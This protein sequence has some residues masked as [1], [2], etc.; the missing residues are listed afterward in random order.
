MADTKTLGTLNLLDSTKW[1]AVERDHPF[2]N[3]DREISP[4]CGGSMSRLKH[5]R[6]RSVPL[7][8]D[9]FIY[10]ATAAVR[11]TNRNTLIAELIAAR[12]RTSGAKYYVR[13]VDNQVAAD[14]WTI[15]TF[16]IRW[17]LLQY[18]KRFILMPVILETN[19]GQEIPEGLNTTGL[20]IANTLGGL[21]TFILGSDGNPASIAGFG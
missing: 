17:S 7:P 1:K 14:V 10:G 2:P 3:Y 8:I 15:I 12:D 19:Y 18:H 20:T 6:V 4:G 11:E 13:K 21:G 9:F 16:S 5:D